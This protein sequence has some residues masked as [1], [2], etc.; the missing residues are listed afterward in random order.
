M[1]KRKKK[2]KTMM[3]C[4]LILSVFVAG[5][6]SGKNNVK[7]DSILHKAK[8]VL[9][10]PEASSTAESQPTNTS[11]HQNNR[12]ELKLVSSKY[13]IKNNNKPQLAMVG[14]GYQFDKRAAAF[15]NNMLNDAKSNGLDPII[16][17]AYRSVE[18]QTMLYNQQVRKWEDTGL[19]YKDACAKAKTVVAYPGT[20]EHNLGLGVDIVAF[21][22]Q[23]LD[24]EQANTKEIIWLTKNCYKYGFIV[25][26]PSGKTDHTGVIF[27]PWHFRYVG[28]EAATEIMNAGICLE[29]YL[30]KG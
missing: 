1:I 10:K 23:L 8:E 21:S 12:W 27:E 3:T 29:E 25:R 18:Q 13:P 2:F 15:L 17:S 7:S 14:N 5:F 22:Y 6:L 19:S 26:Y 30:G 16:C 9:Q 28:V 24:K 4:C 20:S 11:V